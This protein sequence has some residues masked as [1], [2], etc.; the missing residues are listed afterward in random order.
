LSALTVSLHYLPRYLGSTAISNKWQNAYYRNLK[1]TMLLLRNKDQQQKNPLTS[2]AARWSISELQ[3][4]SC[5]KPGLWTW[6]LCSVSVLP[7]NK[8][9]LQEFN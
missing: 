7:A 9:S 1:L 5:M 6:L 4:H 3:A 2:S 8:L